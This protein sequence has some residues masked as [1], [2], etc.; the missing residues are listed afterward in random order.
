MTTSWTMLWL[1]PACVFD[2][3]AGF[4]ERFFG[5]RSR[6]AIRL[7]EIDGPVK[8]HGFAPR[9][10]GAGIGDGLG[11]YTGHIP[12]QATE[13]DLQRVADAQGLNTLVQIL[14]IRTLLLQLLV[15]RQDFF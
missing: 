4:P 5:F 15:L 8:T 1:L 3:V 12:F 14:E 11:L 10:T 9:R 2:V 7:H 6:V 13:L